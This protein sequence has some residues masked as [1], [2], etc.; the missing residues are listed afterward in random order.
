MR[1]VEAVPLLTNLVRQLDAPH[2]GGKGSH[3]QPAVIPAPDQALLARLRAVLRDLNGCVEKTDV[4]SVAKMLKRPWWTA[5]RNRCAAAMWRWCRTR[6][7]KQQGSLWD[8]IAQILWFHG[9]DVDGPPWRKA[10]DRLKSAHSGQRHP[11]HRRSPRRG[12]QRR[13]PSQ[14]SHRR[15]RP[16]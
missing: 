15:R 1:L 10:G 5:Q 11:R 4:V 8:D 16:Q 6:R 2:E 14:P 3:V 13:T 12:T 7:P 9:W